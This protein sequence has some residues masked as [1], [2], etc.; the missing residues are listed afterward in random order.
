[1]ALTKITHRVIADNSILSSMIA[2]GAINSSHVSNLTTDNIAEG[3]N[4]YYT[5]VRADSDINVAIT[6]LINGAPD[7]LNTLGEIAAAINNDSAFSTTINNQ[8]TANR[9]NVY[10]ASGTLLN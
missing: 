3:S 6:N 10:N 9:I 4:L 5:T 1:V 2:D 8:I 7:Q